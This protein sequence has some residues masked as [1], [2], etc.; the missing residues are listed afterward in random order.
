MQNTFTNIC[1]SELPAY[2]RC[3]V[4]LVTSAV[5]GTVVWHCVFSHLGTLVCSVFLCFS[6]FA[7][8]GG[9]HRRAV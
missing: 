5:Y 7:M 4:S 9:I 8:F 3:V 6:R 2:S 1:K